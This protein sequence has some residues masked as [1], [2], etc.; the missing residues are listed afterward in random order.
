[1]VSKLPFKGEFEKDPRIIDVDFRYSLSD[2]QRIVKSY[3][4]NP[5]QPK[6]ELIKLLLQ[7]GVKL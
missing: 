6:R 1:M 7:K 3:G 2:L 4:I 5:R